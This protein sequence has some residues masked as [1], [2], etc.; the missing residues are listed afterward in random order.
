MEKYKEIKII[1]KADSSTRIE[2]SGL[3]F[4]NESYVTKLIV[5]FTYTPVSAWTKWIDFK[6]SDGTSKKI[7]LTN[8]PIVEYILDDS[9]TIAGNLY[10]QPYATLQEEEIVKKIYFKERII[11]I[12]DILG[13]YED[14]S[15]QHPDVIITINNRLLHLETNKADQEYVNE[16]FQEKEAG[17]G[18]SQENFTPDSIS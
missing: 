15:G 17:K 8:D 14:S 2:T 12:N 18:L 5:D 4:A 16:T 3:N 9:V 7:E 1:C 10:V 13:V 11:G 6:M